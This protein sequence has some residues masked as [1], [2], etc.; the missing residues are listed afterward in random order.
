MNGTKAASK[1]IT[2]EKYIF[3]D[4]ATEKLRDK[5]EN[6]NASEEVK[7]G[8]PVHRLNV[9]S[10]VDGIADKGTYFTVTVG[11]PWL[12][13]DQKLEDAAVTVSEILT[14]LSRGSV[15]QRKAVLTVCLGNKNITADSI[16]PLCAEGLIT[17]RHLKTEQPHIW[18]ALGETEISALTPG[19]SG[20]TGIETCE[21]VEAAVK[22]VS[23]DLV[24]AV[25]AISARS[26]ERLGTSIQISDTGISPGSGVG[27]H[28]TAL[29]RET[30]GVPVISVG[31]PTVAHAVTLLRDAAES[32]G[33]K[34]TTEELNA[35][36]EAGRELF[37]T[38][39]DIDAAVKTHADIIARAVNLAFS[40]F[41]RL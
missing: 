30:L 33:A 9:L 41:S 29:N 28:R 16:G 39:K 8:F 5:T 11:K 15:S 13:T 21:L 38:P 27:N 2:A 31:V 34:E 23:P 14:E 35:F 26:T 7:H 6:V 12:D 1:P 17:T 32:S 19:V 4:M 10:T 36:L 40:G 25:D 37:I 3:T 24:I 20:M 18:K 22:A